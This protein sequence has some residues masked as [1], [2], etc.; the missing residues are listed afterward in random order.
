MNDNVDNKKSFLSQAT[1][2]VK[3]NIRNIIILKIK[4]NKI[5][6][7][8]WSGQIAHL[9][10]G[11]FAIGLILNVSQSY[12]DEFITQEGEIITFGNQT[13][14]IEKAYEVIKE[15]KDIINLPIKLNNNYKNASLN[16]FKNSSQQAISSPAI[17]RNLESD[18]YV[19]IKFIDSKSFK[20]IFRK[21]YGIL[22]MWIGLALSTLSVIPRIKSNEK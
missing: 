19:T 16:I 12:S 13:Y 3:T 21:N 14:S 1:E 17:F 11:V 22:I 6:G 9:G 5:N 20:L 18:T 15:E 7:T 8:Y 4:F 2:L 10:I